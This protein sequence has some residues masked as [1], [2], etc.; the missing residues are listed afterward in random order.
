MG[1]IYTVEFTVIATFSAWMDPQGH[2]ARSANQPAEAA[3]GSTLLWLQKLNFLYRFGAVAAAASHT[4]HLCPCNGAHG[5]AKSETH[6]MNVFAE[7]AD[8]TSRPVT[9]RS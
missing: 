7:E 4:I 5:D 2:A 3:G 6:L 9:P 8:N 1:T